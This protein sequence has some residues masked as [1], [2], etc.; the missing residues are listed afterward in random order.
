[1]GP[2]PERQIALLDKVSRYV[3]KKH[4]GAAA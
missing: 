2:D 1:L 3:L 4:P